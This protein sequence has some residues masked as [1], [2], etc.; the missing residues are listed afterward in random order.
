MLY[1]IQDHGGGKVYAIAEVPFPDKGPEQSPEQLAAGL[2]LHF[3]GV[4][5][6]TFN[7]SPLLCS[8][9]DGG[10]TAEDRVVITFSESQTPREWDIPD[11]HF[12]V[13]CVAGLGN[14]SK[15]E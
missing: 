9:G 10:Y 1:S 5:G 8:D 2:A 6:M 13:L 3:E 7:A 12:A 15:A 4:P 14:A 11:F